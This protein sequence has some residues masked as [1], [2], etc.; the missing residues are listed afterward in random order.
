MNLYYNKQWHLLYKSVLLLLVKFTIEARQVNHEWIHSTSIWVVRKDCDLLRRCKREGLFCLMIFFFPQI[1]PGA[2]QC[3]LLV[4]LRPR[5]S[6]PPLLPASSLCGADADVQLHHEHDLM[7]TSS[8]VTRQEQEE[9]SRRSRQPQATHSQNVSVHFWSGKACFFF[10]SNTRTSYCGK[11]IPT[12]KESYCLC[13]FLFSYGGSLTP[14]PFP[15]LFLPP[16]DKILCSS[17]AGHSAGMRM[18]WKQ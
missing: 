16:T 5:H 14:P 10:P 18:E 3:P 13:L 12:R 6:G 4:D 1:C 15:L 17:G 2:V 7:L 8:H 11:L 9:A